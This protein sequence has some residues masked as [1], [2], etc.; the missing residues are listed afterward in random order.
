MENKTEIANGSILTIYGPGS[1]RKHPLTKEILVENRQLM[2]KAKVITNRPRISAVIIWEQAPVK[3]GYD[4]VFE[5]GP[6]PNG[7]P[8]LGDAGARAFISDRLMA[9]KTHYGAGYPC[10]K[11]H[12]HQLANYGP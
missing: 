5:Q 3:P 2:A 8:Q 6:R 10:P 12:P 11:H 9:R 4:A 1:V 7:G